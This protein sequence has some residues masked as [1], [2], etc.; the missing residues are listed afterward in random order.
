MGFVA[1][2][3]EVSTTFTGAFTS[4]VLATAKEGIADAELN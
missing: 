3:L 2:Y 1:G 4:I